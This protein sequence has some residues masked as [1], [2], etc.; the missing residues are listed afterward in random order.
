MILH[1]RCVS[2]T[3]KKKEGNVQYFVQVG[4]RNRKNYR[5]IRMKILNWHK[6]FGRSQKIN[7]REFQVQSGSYRI[8]VKG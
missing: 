6:A 7:L 2:K 4:V 3:E 1:I 5:L 8:N